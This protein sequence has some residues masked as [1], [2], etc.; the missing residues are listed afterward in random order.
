MTRSKICG[1]QL[2]LLLAT[3]LLHGQEPPSTEG[4]RN[5]LRVLRPTIRARSHSA[6]ATMGTPAMGSG[7][8]KSKNYQFASADFPGSDISAALDE[9]TSTAVGY[10]AYISS[11]VAFTL[12]KGS[13]QLSGR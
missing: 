1:L 11:L 10:F 6:A 5:L 13:Y 2:G 8:A 9:N 7:D 12:E 3:V 4:A